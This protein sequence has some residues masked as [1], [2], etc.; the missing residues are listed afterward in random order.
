MC[1]FNMKKYGIYRLTELGYM[2]CELSA[3]IAFTIHVNRPPVYHTNYTNIYV[4]LVIA[5]RFCYACMPCMLMEL[6]VVV[7]Q[8]TLSN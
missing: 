3:I 6:L 1:P 7:L 8:C 4:K 5:V 2:T